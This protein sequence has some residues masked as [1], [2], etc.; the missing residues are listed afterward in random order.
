[1]VNFT[2]T[3]YQ[4]REPQHWPRTLGPRCRCP[5]PRVDVELGM[6][7]PHHP[8]VEPTH[9]VFKAFDAM[10]G[11]ARARKFVRL[12]WKDNH[13]SW[14]FHILERAEQLFAA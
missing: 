9:D 12:A 2:E 6:R 4:Q 7:Y 13:D 10:P 11:F 8:L 3:V 14:A 5:L 1:M